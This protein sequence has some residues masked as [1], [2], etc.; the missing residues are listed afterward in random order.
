MFRYNE[1]DLHEHRK[2]LLRS[3]AQARLAGQANVENSLS[4]RFGR[5]LLTWGAHF[6]V[7]DDCQ[8]VETR[9]RQSVMICPV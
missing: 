5:V 3:A 4:E 2:E 7:K 9:G 1:Y 8:R 6:A